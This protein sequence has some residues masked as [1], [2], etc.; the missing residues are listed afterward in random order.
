[1]FFKAHEDLSKKQKQFVFALRSRLEEDDFLFKSI[2]Y[3]PYL[4]RTQKY[5]LK[6]SNQDI[7]DIFINGT[8]GNE[9]KVPI[10]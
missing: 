6:K 8:D 10:I 1:M 3:V 2:R 7:N 4:T 5:L 9:L